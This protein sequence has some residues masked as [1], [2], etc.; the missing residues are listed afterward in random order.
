MNLSCI[1][2]VLVLTLLTASCANIPITNSRWYADIGTQGAVWAETQTVDS[3][4]VKQPQWDDMRFGMICTEAKT[5]AD[6]KATIEKLCSVSG[7]CTYQIKQQF[8]QFF[9]NIEYLERVAKST[10]R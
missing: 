6:W 2:T 7:K 1:G 9:E 10:P 3:G 5:F 4:E 8:N